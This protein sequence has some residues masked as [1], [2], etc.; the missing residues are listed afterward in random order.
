M[1]TFGEAP[2]AQLVTLPQDYPISALGLKHSLIWILWTKLPLGPR[3]FF[4]IRRNPSLFWVCSQ[5]PCTACVSY[6]TWPAPPVYL[7][8]WE[9]FACS[10]RRGHAV[11]C[12][13]SGIR[14][15]M[16]AIGDQRTL[17]MLILLNLFS[18]LWV[19]G[20]SNQS[21]MCWILPG[22]FKPIEDAA[23]WGLWAPNSGGWHCYD[24]CHSL[25]TVENLTW[26]W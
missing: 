14:R 23:G 11:H 18:F 8:P 16:L 21:L 25:R 24:L 2:I 20:C 3:F 4:L 5:L 26:D 6:S 10:T 12:P 15:N 19:K 13:V 17:Q 22:D 1:C 9:V 7:P